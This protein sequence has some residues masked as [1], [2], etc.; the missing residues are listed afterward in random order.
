MCLRR[1][2]CDTIAKCHILTLKFSSLHGL[3]LALLSLGCLVMHKSCEIS[4][5]SLD[6][7]LPS[8]APPEYPSTESDEQ[9][10]TLEQTHRRIMSLLVDSTGLPV[11]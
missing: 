7:T 6:P 8:P 10:G 4:T 2:V 3:P 11:L 1:S 9:P 5:F